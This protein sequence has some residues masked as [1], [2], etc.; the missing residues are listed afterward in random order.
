MRYRMQLNREAFNA[1]RESR[2]WRTQEEAAK[3]MGINPTTLSNALTG[4]VGVGAD[5]IGKVSAQFPGLPIDR[6]V[7]VVS[8]LEEAA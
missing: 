7:T 3:A 6:L 4:R 2:R 1:L 5:F 8:D